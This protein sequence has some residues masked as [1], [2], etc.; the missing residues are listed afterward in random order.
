MNKITLDE[1]AE[2][3]SMSKSHISKIFNEG[4]G[5]SISTYINRT[6][7]ERSKRLLKSTTLTIAEIAVL[8]GFEDQSYY[9][10]QFKAE[11]GLSPKEFRKR[12]IP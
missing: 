12:A 11:T 8:T 3:V 6:R 4:M 1:I 5:V 10:K 9:T 2:H 7:I